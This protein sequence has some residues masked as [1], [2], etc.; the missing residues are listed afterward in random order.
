M[1][2]KLKKRWRELT[3]AQTVALILVG[4]FM[5]FMVIGIAAG[6]TEDRPAEQEK[7]NYPKIA[8]DGT[9]KDTQ[10]SAPTPPPPP[11]TPPPT[12]PKTYTG[13]GDNVL[14]IE[15][16]NDRAAI[17]AFSCPSCTGNTA[18]ETNGYESL[19]VNEIGSYS[20]RHLIDSRGGSIT[21]ELTITATSAWTVTVSGTDHARTELSGHGDEVILVG[22]TGRKAAISNVGDSNFIVEVYPLDG[23]SSDLAV[24]TI[25][26]Y[27][28]TV[29]LDAPALVQ[30]TSNGDWTVTP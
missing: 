1:S 16:P 23:G 29:P 2:G 30:I 7:V 4:F 18:V 9:L 14:T 3:G 8:A 19:I 27:K 11:A 24:N 22:G 12:T 20:G 6:P 25:G 17:V 26:S 21:T 28:G 5:F 15:K 13:S 10:K